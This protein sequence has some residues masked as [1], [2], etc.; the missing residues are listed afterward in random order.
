MIKKDVY[1]IC[2]FAK[3]KKLPFSLSSSHSSANF[4]LLHLD[5]WS[6]I[7]TA[8]IYSHRYFLTIV[9]DHSRYVWVVL[10]KSKA[11]V[12]SRV[13]NFIVMIENQYHTTPKTI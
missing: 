4:E 7:S 5:I 11:E 8:S 13:R 3:H 9:D 6:P 1:D 12:S 2:H 10:L